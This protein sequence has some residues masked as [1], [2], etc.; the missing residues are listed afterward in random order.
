MKHLFTLMFVLSITMHSFAQDQGTFLVDGSSSIDFSSISSDQE[1]NPYPSE[2]SVKISSLNIDLKPAYFLADGLALGLSIFN[3]S[4]T[5]IYEN[6]AIPDKDENKSSTFAF[7]PMV[8]YYVSDLGLYADLSYVFGNVKSE[9][10]S[11]GNTTTVDEDKMSQ[12]SFGLGYAIFL[13]DE[14]ALSPSLNYVSM[15]TTVEEGATSPTTGNLVDQVY[16]NNGIRF[17]L[18]LSVFFGN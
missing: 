3:E 13:S 6:T 10:S 15:K 14:I 16:S 11:T 18:G 8:R 17:Q 5:T 9:Y 7:G 2:L 12:L 4:S 1:V